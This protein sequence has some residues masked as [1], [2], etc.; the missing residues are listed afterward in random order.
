MSTPRPQIGQ[1]VEVRGVGG[2]WDGMRLRVTSLPNRGNLARGLVV[3]PA[4]SE[5]LR[6]RYVV[7]DQVT[8]YSGVCHPVGFGAW[9]KE[10]S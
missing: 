6:N 7:G 3:V 9:Y 8:L 5:R 1:T 10:H 4:P 2:G